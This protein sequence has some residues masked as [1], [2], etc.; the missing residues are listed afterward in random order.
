M[1]LT[2]FT[3]NHHCRTF[4]SPYIILLAIPLL[5]LS[6]LCASY[7]L[8]AARE[9]KR[10]ESIARSPVFEA[11]GSL[12][13]GVT[14]IRASERTDAYISSLFSKLDDHCRTL[15]YT[16]CFNSWLTIRLGVIGAIF[17]VGMALMVI[18]LKSISAS[19]AGFVLM[20]TLDYSDAVMWL[21]R[22]C[23]DIELG[24]NS[25]ERI[26]E[27][28][29]IAI[30]NQEGK[31]VP[32]TWPTEG[33]FTVTDLVVGYAP[34]LPPTLNNLS[35]KILPSE[36]IGVVGR[37]GAGKSSL[38][39]AIFR[40]LEARQ[41]SIVIDGIDI[42]KV[43][44]Q[45]LRS[46]LIII[47]QNPVL[48]SGTIRSNLDPFDSHSDEDILQ[49]LYRV[50]LISSAELEIGRALTPRS[51]SILSRNLFA[52]LQSQIG[53]GGH[54]FS[55]GQRQLLCLARAIISR[56]KV[57][58]L[59]EATSAVD[60]ETDLLIQ[61]SIREEFT[62]CT[63]IVIAHRLSTVI[64]FDKILVLGAGRKLEFGTPRELIEADRV[65]AGMLRQ[66]GDVVEY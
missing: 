60:K 46:R 63:L 6:S 14:T 57:L 42:A 12:L 41:G 8:Q 44:L 52:D 4:I 28:S 43:K 36:R 31:E 48:F 7:Y 1:Y 34:D 55:Q 56:P 32:A 33:A 65:F 20:A 15:W 10:I 16:W 40:V 66:S 29:E 23:S 22:Q 49:A 38:A 37:T 18:F 61:R 13:A 51:T 58:I 5:A 2:S 11:F 9:T 62:N 3:A 47:P 27:Y 64:D 35:F 17:T 59:D 39:L 24:M 50:H 25:V 26:L 53:E 54:N 19:M 30:E 21:L 45:D